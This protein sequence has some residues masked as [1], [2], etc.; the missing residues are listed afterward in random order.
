MK[1]SARLTRIND[2]IM[3]EV[4]E[5]IR[6]GLKDPRIGSMTSV[7]KVDTTNDLAYCKVYVSVYGDEE[8]KKEVMLGLGNAAGFIRREIAHRIN[9]R[10]TPTF[11]FLLDDS[12]EY[13]DRINRL[14]REVN[15]SEEQREPERQEQD[16]P[17]LG[18]DGDE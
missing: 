18:D 8:Q 12:M 16:E 9:L 4:A 15:S 3:K 5:I 14:I 10:N 1:G 11:K 6:S 2:E 13:S 7:L 17:D